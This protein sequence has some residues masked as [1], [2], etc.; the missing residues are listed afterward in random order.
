M[1]ELEAQERIVVLLPVFNDWQAVGRLLDQIDAALAG[2]SLRPEIL[3]VDDGST[4][5]PPLEFPGRSY[6]AIRSVDMLH[7]C[8]NLGHQRAIA[9]GLVHV[10]QQIPCRAVVVMDADGEDQPEYIPALLDK[11]RQEGERP[12]V[13]AA[14]AKRLET[15]LF[16]FLC[17][18]YELVVPPHRGREGQGAATTILKWHAL[19]PFLLVTRMVIGY[20]PGRLGTSPEIMP[21][22]YTFGPLIL[23]TG[24][25]LGVRMSLAGLSA[26]ACP[27][28]VAAINNK[29]TVPMIQL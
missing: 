14:R 7:L 1:S 11:F 13:F 21:A 24:S 8:R 29:T 6:R 10:H 9:V 2:E 28:V 23:G 20:S 3:I 12:I 4:E 16:R 17:R 26:A 19:F 18:T 25:G 5:A 27:T 22:P 15:P